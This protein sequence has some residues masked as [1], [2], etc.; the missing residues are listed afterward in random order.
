MIPV[1]NEQPKNVTAVITSAVGGK[2]GQGAYKL[3]IGAAIAVGV[4]SIPFVAVG[5]FTSSDAPAVAN[6]APMLNRVQAQPAVVPT[7]AQYGYESAADARNHC[8]VGEV[9]IEW[10]GGF[11]CNKD[12]DK[13]RQQ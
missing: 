6:I 11:S 4:C 3:I 1:A 5:W 7:L 13:Y 12:M 9:V 10:R 8:A 2:I